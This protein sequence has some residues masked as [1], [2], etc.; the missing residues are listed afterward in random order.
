MLFD[1][2]IDNVI[3]MWIM[4]EVHGLVT[5]TGVQTVHSNELNT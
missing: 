5:E 2:D 4:T 1:E 3:I